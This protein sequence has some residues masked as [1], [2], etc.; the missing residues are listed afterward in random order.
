MQSYVSN[1]IRLQVH[2]MM[3]ATGHWLGRLDVVSCQQQVRWLVTYL[4]EWR[5]WA[6][7]RQPQD[8]CSD[9][10]S[11]S[12]RVRRDSA[13][14]LSVRLSVRPVRARTC[15]VSGRNDRR[16]VKSDRHSPTCSL[17][18]PTRPSNAEVSTKFLE[19]DRACQLR[20]RAHVLMNMQISRRRQ[21]I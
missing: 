7:I 18:R 11:A 17:Q 1:C 20:M 10:P 2:Q 4:V 3:T 8:T 19:G 14:S 13:L 5:R 15:P 12:A 16:R 21:H 6:V 9:H